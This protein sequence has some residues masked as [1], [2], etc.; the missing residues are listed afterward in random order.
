MMIAACMLVALARSP[1]LTRSQPIWHWLLIGWHSTSLCGWLPKDNAMFAGIHRTSTSSL[2][3]DLSGT[4]MGMAANQTFRGIHANSSGA[5]A[6]LA[7]EA[8]ADIVSGSTMNTRDVLNPHA[9]IF[10]Q[11]PLDTL[12][13]TPMVGRAIMGALFNAV[14][15]ADVGRRDR[16]L[17]QIDEAWTLGAMREIK[18]FHTTARRYGACMST[19]W[20]SEGQL[21]EVWGRDGAKI[22]RDTVS[23][24]S[25]NAIQDGEVAE[26]LSRDMGEHSVLAVS[27]G[28]NRGRSRQ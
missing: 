16:V 27:E 4:F 24:R 14:I 17:F 20:Q 5:T 10:V 1:M 21:E 6:W 19:L 26:R 11:L 22:L 7:T 18:L 28:S 2:A 25:F 13:V 9:V 8:Y 3:R 15:H 12:L 23:W